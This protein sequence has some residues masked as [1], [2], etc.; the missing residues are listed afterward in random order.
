MGRGSGAANDA[1]VRDRLARSAA[2]ALG[3]VIK[4]FSGEADARSRQENA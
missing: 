1:S 4:A 2:W 3:L